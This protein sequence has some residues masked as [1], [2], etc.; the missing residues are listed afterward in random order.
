M[1]GVGK[2][3]MRRTVCTIQLDRRVG[4][5]TLN[6]KHPSSNGALTFSSAR[7]LRKLTAQW[8]AA[9]LVEIWNQLPGVR[10]VTRFTD[11]DTAIRR[12][13]AVVQDLARADGASAVDSAEPGTKAE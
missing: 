3:K 11:R 12:I 6:D 8:P 13:W 10:K 7:K 9:Q 4:I 2:N 1:N 5:L